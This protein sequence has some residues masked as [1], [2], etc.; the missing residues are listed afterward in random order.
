MNRTGEVNR[1]VGPINVV[2]SYDGLQA[3]RRD[4]CIYIYLYRR[5]VRFH[6][7]K[8]RMYLNVECNKKKEVQGKGETL[9]I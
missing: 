4:I 3:G 1:E 7:A 2:M 6:F 9:G 5:K 8:C